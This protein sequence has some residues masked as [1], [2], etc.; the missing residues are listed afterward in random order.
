LTGVPRLLGAVLAGGAGRRFGSDKAAA[1]V[2]GVPLVERAA[3]T[4]ERVFGEVVVVSSRG[5]VEGRTTIPDLRAGAGP[6]AGIESAL[7]RAS[8]SG[9]DG[10]FV[11]ACDL[12]LVTAE[13]V[14][15]IV[16]ALGPGAAAAA[17]RD[18]S[19]PFEPLCAAYRV[20]ALGDVRALLDGGTRTARALFEAV[21]GVRVPAPADEL[22]NVNTA[23]DAACAEASLRDRP[24]G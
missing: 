15:A 5:S 9:L 3:R 2:A 20:T 1:V 18:G 7:A 23:Q 17:A 4:L 13:T 8:D 11:L 6:L 14:R 21:G 10:A 16:S 24:D 19:P 12:P 22:H